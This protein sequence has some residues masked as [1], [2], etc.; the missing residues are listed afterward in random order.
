MDPNVFEATCNE[1]GASNL[2][3]CIRDS[4]Y[5]DN[6]SEERKHLTDMPTMVIIYVMKYYQS[7]KSN[8]F[9]I[10]LSRTLQ[11]FAATKQGLF[12]KKA[13]L[14]KK[15]KPWRI[16]LLL[17]VLYGGWTLIRDMMLSVF[18]KCK[19]NFLPSLTIMSH[20]FWASTQLLSS[21]TSMNFSA[22]C[23]P[24][25]GFVCCVLKTALQ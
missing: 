15:P 13:K 22:V 1:A 10:A 14:A 23:A 19:L 18:Y 11:Q 9:Q 21:A 2:Y 20:W 3:K 17:K 8:A 12:L 24:L 7:Q 16:S 5:S 25:L 4:I 6:L